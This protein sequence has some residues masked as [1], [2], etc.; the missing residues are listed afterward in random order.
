MAKLDLTQTITVNDVTYD[1]SDFYQRKL[2]VQGVQPT[3]Y[4]SHVF[5]DVLV[6][7]KNTK[8]TQNGEK[9]GGIAQAIYRYQEIDDI[10]KFNE[11]QYPFYLDVVMTGDL[12]P[13]ITGLR[14]HDAL[15]RRKKPFT[16]ESAK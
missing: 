3:N 8:T 10:H 6:S 2:L 16:V 9:A 15:E 12:E 1:P 5:I 14:E 7:H 11:H 4:E 13:I